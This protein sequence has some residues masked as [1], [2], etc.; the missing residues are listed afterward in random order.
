[1]RFTEQFKEINDTMQ[2]KGRKH[3]DY[4]VGNIK[5]YKTIQESTRSIKFENDQSM[6]KEKKGS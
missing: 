4:R 5:I 6:T 3:L 1:M 2:Q